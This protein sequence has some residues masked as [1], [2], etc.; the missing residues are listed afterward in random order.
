VDWL[1]P[2]TAAVLRGLVAEPDVVP[3]P[4]PAKIS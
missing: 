1:A 3:A 2:A 4:E